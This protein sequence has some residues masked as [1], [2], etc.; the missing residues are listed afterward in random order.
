MKKNYFISDWAIIIY[1]A[2]FKIIF[3]LILPEYG[4]FRD[5]YYYISI[6]DQ[7]SFSNLDMLPLSPLYLKLITFIFGYSIKSIHF[8]SSLLGA[9]ALVVTCLISKE[10]GGKK[11]AIFLSG[12]VIIFSGL[13]PFGSI[14]TYDSIDF[15]VSIATLYI[16]IKIFKSNNQ[17]LWYYAGIVLGLALMN[18]LT[19]LFLG[20]GILVSILLVHH[21][22]MLKSKQVWFAGII[23]LLFLLPYLIWQSQNDWYFINFASNYAGG[24]SY[25][26]SFPEFLWNQILPNNPITLPVW[27]TG[28]FTLLFS[29]KNKNFRFFGILYLFLF[30]FYFII[31]AKYYFLVPMYAVLLAAGAVKIEERLVNSLKTKIVIPIIFVILSIPLIPYMVPLL[32]VE[33]LTKYVCFLGVD[34]GVK[35]ENQKLNNLPQHFADRFGWVELAR[36]IAFEFNQIPKEERNNAGIITNNWGI[37]SAIHFYRNKYNLP[38]PISNDGWYYFEALKKNINRKYFISVGISEQDL[39]NY[40][41]KVTLKRI[42]TNPYCMPHENNRPIFLCEKPKID[43]NQ[44][45]RVERKINPGFY[46]ILLKDGAKKA[47]QYFETQKFF[48]ENIFFFTETQIN[49][50]GYDFLKDNRF[51]D[52]ILLFELN[53]KTFPNSF[54]VYDSYADALMKVGRYEESKRYY[55]KSI[56]LNPNNEN[57]KLKLRELSTLLNKKGFCN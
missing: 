6:A 35:Y 15:L 22:K 37:A 38:E 41:E 20:F 45:I 44:L 23:A 51:E 43:L 27:L 26:A 31:G 32:N 54:N 47:I 5:E 56:E 28:L 16:L 42:F 8:A 36:E 29:S 30:F 53:L 50:I 39:K 33:S 1:L 55:L 18:K 25:I 11:Y 10:L 57:G 48:N 46:S 24:I 9:L 34:A 4:Y 2:V 17:N 40:F 49:H 13:L 14:F 21:R 19:I 12:L 3:H 7:F 52:A